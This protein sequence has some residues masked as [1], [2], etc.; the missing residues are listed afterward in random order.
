MIPNI[1]HFLFI[2]YPL[3]NI[4]IL[5]PQLY[6]NERHIGGR[7]DFNNLAK[8]DLDELIKYVMENEPPAEG[9]P[10]IPDQELLIVNEGN[11]VIY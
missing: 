2:L 10:P 6:F 9:M 8:E 11:L 5:V 1:W 3:T 4:P 7:D